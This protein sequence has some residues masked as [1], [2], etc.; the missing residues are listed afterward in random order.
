VRLSQDNQGAFY[1][2]LRIVAKL[3]IVLEVELAELLKMPVGPSQR[4][5]G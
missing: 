4:V 1:A 3:A 5:K 2:S